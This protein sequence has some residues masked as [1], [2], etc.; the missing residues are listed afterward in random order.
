MKNYRMT[1]V[2]Q[3]PANRFIFL[4]SKMKLFIWIFLGVLIG[5]LVSI[6]IDYSLLIIPGL[7][8][9]GL[10]LLSPIFGLLLYVI[11][12][13][14][15]PGSFPIT[16]IIFVLTIMS[17]LL[18]FFSKRSEYSNLVKSPLYW[19]LGGMYFLG[20]LPIFFFD[21]VLDNY[22]AEFS[23]PLFFIG[24]SLSSILIFNT[25]NSE[26]KLDYIFIVT[27][28]V[29]III[30]LICIGQFFHLS[31][32]ILGKFIEKKTNIIPDPLF[33]EIRRATG[34]FGDGPT[35]GFL[36][37]TLLFLNIGKFFSDKNKLKRCFFSL[38]SLLILFATF[39]TL[40]RSIWF[41]TV[42]TFFYLWLKKGG[43]VR[44]LVLPLI[45]LSIFAFSFK[46]RV[47]ERIHLTYIE[48]TE[49]DKVRTDEVGHLIALLKRV[50]ENPL[51]GT[52]IGRL[53]EYQSI[54]GYLEDQGLF[55]FVDPFGDPGVYAG[56]FNELED[57]QYSHSSF[58]PGFA[59]Q[60]GIGG[61]LLILLL[62]F[63]TWRGLTQTEHFCR[64]A[65]NSK[66]LNLTEGLKVTLFGILVYHIARGHPGD[67][68]FWFVVGLSWAV[69]TIAERG[70]K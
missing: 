2:H 21:G 52:G 34:T 13:I 36:L 6:R 67:R 37:Q 3:F 53:N 26:K 40:A 62:I 39:A 14:F 42:L 66:L 54:K 19:I 16:K 60:L 55:Y 20:L 18:Q 35:T 61:L 12:F 65:E 15:P 8:T 24:N 57:I 9:L 7:I 29:G 5:A 25:V 38:T 58:F 64:I 41:T 30:S 69:K 43:K 23:D 47:Q 50:V 28:I 22:L 59:A 10:I 44:V 70:V 56:E 46:D 31:P 11:C 51:I 27:A 1:S 63:Y 32:N 68:M 48:F 45:I 33:G 4:P 17:W 49:Q